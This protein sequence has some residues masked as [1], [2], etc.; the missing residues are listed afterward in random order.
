M[1]FIPR[2]VSPAPGQAPAHSP[3]HRLRGGQVRVLQALSGGRVLTRDKL[4]AEIG[5]SPISGTLSYLLNGMKVSKANP[6]GHPG[7]VELGM[8]TRITLDID[9]IEEV[10][11][12]ITPTGEEALLH[13][14]DPPPIGD[15]SKNVNRRYRKVDPQGS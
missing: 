2:V 11:Y 3:P 8:V 13:A 15:Q 9:G 12:R 10:C 7:L 5:L 6:K 14:P 1:V 4:R